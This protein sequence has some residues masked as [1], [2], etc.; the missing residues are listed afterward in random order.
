MK[1]KVNMMRRVSLS[2]P[3]SYGKQSEPSLQFKTDCGD[4]RWKAVMGEMI[5]EIT[6]APQ[7]VVTFTVEKGQLCRIRLTEGSQVI[8]MSYRVHLSTMRYNFR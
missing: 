4:R 5:N 7:S 3:R 6:C 2:Q 8:P 1:K